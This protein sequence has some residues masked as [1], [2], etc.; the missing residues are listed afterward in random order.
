[1]GIPLY[2]KTISDKYPEII[3]ELENVESVNGLFL[4][5][6]CAIHPCSRKIAMENYKAH[7]KNQ[8]ERLEAIKKKYL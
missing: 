1:M 7:K 4:D 6:N 8:I 5:L 3:I 2:F